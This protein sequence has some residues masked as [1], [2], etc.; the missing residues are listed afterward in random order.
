MIEP[1]VFSL[2]RG[3][4]NRGRL[5]GEMARFVAGQ[6]ALLFGGE[7]GC[8]MRSVSCAEFLLAQKLKQ[9]AQGPAGRNVGLVRLAVRRNGPA[10][11]HKRSLIWVRTLA[12]NRHAKLE[13][14]C[15]NGPGDANFGGMPTALQNVTQL[16]RAQSRVRVATLF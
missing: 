6:N 11:N 13:V 8:A 15:G 9:P 10:A 1:A 4:K 12:R 3:A 2:M 14:G 5:Q 7:F 16:W